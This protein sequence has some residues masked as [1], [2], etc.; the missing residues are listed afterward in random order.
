MPLL[1]AWEPD[2]VDQLRAELSQ[3]VVLEGPSTMVPVM[4]AAG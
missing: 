2:E 4:S 1:E 3:P